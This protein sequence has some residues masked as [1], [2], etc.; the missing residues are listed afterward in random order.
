MTP[1]SFVKT[2]ESY[3][4]CQFGYHLDSILTETDKT[5]G[6]NYRIG[7]DCADRAAIVGSFCVC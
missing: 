5:H 6:P 4:V 7:P 3:K 2:M 1:V